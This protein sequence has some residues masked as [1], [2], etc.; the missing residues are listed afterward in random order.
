MSQVANK[1]S[2]CRRC[3]NVNPLLS[4]T[5][6]RKCHGLV[7]CDVDQIPEIRR[8]REMAQSIICEYVRKKYWEAYDNNFGPGIRKH[9]RWV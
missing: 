1:G 5:T 3:G 9:W 7:L 8:R 2:V 4:D 6:C